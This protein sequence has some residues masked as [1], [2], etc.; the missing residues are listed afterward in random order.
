[1]QDMLFFWQTYIFLGNTL[2]VYIIAL[3]Y[4]F[5]TL[6][7]LQIFRSF[8]VRR[9][10]R[11]AKKT[12]N[13]FDDAV[14][15]CVDG[16][17]ARFYITLSLYIA[18][19]QLVLTGMVDHIISAVV[20]LVVVSEVA[21]VFGCLIDFFIELYLQKVPKSGRDHARS[22]LRIL[23]GLILL[24]IWALAF[25][26]ILSNLGVNVTAL[27]A[28]MGIG[29]IAVALAL[30]NVLSDIFSSFSIFIDKPFQIGDYI[31][32][33]GK[34]GIVRSIGLKT[35]RLETL[36]GEVLVIPN[37]EITG[38]TIENFRQMRRRRDVVTIGVTYETSTKK[39]ES[40]P[41]I[42]AGIVGSQE[43]VEFS[44]CHLKTLGAYSIDFELVYY[45]N[46]KDY[47]EYMNIREAILSGLLIEFSKKKID[48]AYPTQRIQIEK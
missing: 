5:I 36:R 45:V 12:A 11:L 17:H 46:S 18:S 16:L 48:F 2:W 47:I 27:I 10:E 37:K 31:V 6:L 28:S 39:R 23:R 29:G 20:L 33:G 30:Q 24:V 25:L 21:N 26:V 14:I 13:T 34:D 19:R 9:L 8:V 15:A 22:M 32:L 7:V 42:V 44:R 38:A 41:E 35:T 43:G 4:F 3:G 40:I 1:M